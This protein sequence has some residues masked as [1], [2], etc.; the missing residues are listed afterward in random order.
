MKKYIIRT[1]KY[2]LQFIVMFFV[3]FTILHLT[4]YIKNEI[5]YHQVF[6]STNGVLL[7]C[8][9]LIFALAY[10]KFGFI[11]RTLTFNALLHKDEI[12]NIM[13]MCG[14]E[15]VN[16]DETTMTFR[17]RGVIK[18]TTLLFEDEIVISTIDSLS[19]IEGPRK[20][21]V[22]ASFRFETYIKQQQ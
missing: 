18:K 14:Y 8:F 1:L 20:E 13:Q 7:V 9:V 16:S 11:K 12:V 5:D 17:A 3:L 2:I 10:P 6:V 22:K 21:A 4:G 15:L 19:T